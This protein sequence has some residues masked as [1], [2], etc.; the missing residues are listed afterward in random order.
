MSQSSQLAVW[1][2]IDDRDRDT[3][4]MY[5]D[6]AELY[7]EFH[8]RYPDSLIDHAIESSPRLRNQEPKDIKILELGCGGPG[9][10]TLPLAK[11]GFQITAI[12]PGKGM[13]D[14]AR[15][16]CAD[17]IHTT[18]KFHLA[19]FKDFDPGE[20]K[21]DAVVAGSSLHWALAADNEAAKSVLRKKLHSVLH[22]GGS[23]LLFFGD[24]S[25]V[26]SIS[27]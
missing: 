7:H 15:L 12:D 6:V 21:Y 23:L 19:T 18:V 5:T 8:P 2:L 3:D 11:R 1:S 10:L 16:V 27:L 13:M 17:F 25:V 26:P 4:Q 20:E 24:P 14:K 9:T 22:D